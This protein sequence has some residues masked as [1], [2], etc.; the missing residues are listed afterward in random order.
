M[1]RRCR[2]LCLSAL[3]PLAASCSDKNPVDVATGTGE[4]TVSVDAQIAFVSTRDGS[5]HIYVAKT[6]SLTRLTPG[7]MPAWSPD[8][9]RIAF[10]RSSSDGGRGIVVIDADGSDLRVLHQGGQNPA[11]SADGSRIVFNS[12]CCAPEGGI[13]VMNADG[14]GVVRLISSDFASSDWHD[15]LGWPTWSPDGRSIAFVR[16]PCCW[17]DPW[18]LYLMNADGSEPRTLWPSVGDSRP[19]WSPDGSRLLLQVH[20]SNPWVIGSVDLNGS[21]FRSHTSAFYVG[22]PDWSPDGRSIAFARFSAPLD[23]PLP[24][25]E[26]LPLRTRIFVVDLE[27]G[28]ARQLIPDAVGP[29]VPDYWDSQPTWSRV[30]EGN[31]DNPWDYGLALAQLSAPPP[32]P[33]RRDVHRRSGR[34]P[35]VQTASSRGAALGRRSCQTGVAPLLETRSREPVPVRCARY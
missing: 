18:P 4:I 11:W 8:G 6:G 3:L 2:H 16:A 23:E 17:E 35:R 24:P 25:D 34:E 14:S 12:V 27:G 29:A 15:Y 33:K 7:E 32:Q 10:H 5:P 1:R 20:P 19:V 9:G 13:F 28:P 26:P 22:Y 31:T 21:D 30:R